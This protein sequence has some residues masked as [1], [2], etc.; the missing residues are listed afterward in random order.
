M[1]RRALAR[2]V[3][4]LLALLFLGCDEGRL[5]PGGACA[6]SFDCTDG[7]VCFSVDGPPG[8]DGGRC[9]ELCPSDGS[10][11][12]NDEVCVAAASDP[13][14]QVCYLGGSA[15]IGE[16]C[17]DTT[18]CELG[19]LCVDPGDGSPRCFQAC[20]TTAPAC[21]TELVCEPLEEP[22]G[23]CAVPAEAPEAP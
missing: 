11:C 9:M 10:P 5:E 17:R 6:T 20:D 8:D 4:V 15:V 16:G 19:A 2:G 23:F 13:E 12:E 1:C 21:P 22:G 3:P 14:V 18:E 7:T